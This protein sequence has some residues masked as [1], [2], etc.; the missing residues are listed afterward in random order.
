MADGAKMEA[1]ITLTSNVLLLI[2]QWFYTSILVPSTIYGSTATTE[3]VQKKMF[4]LKTGQMQFLL[5]FGL[6]KGEGGSTKC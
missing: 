1:A 6:E 5:H 3:H 2:S 4:Y